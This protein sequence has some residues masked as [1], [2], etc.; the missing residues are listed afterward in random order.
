M[1]KT[2]FSTLEEAKTELNDLKNQFFKSNVNLKDLKKQ[3]KISPKVEHIIYAV[4]ITLGVIIL[5]FI[6][7]NI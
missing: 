5:L 4:A 1:K 6:L 3:L 7:V 2:S